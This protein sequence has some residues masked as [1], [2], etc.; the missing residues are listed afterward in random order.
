MRQ[1]GHQP[2]ATFQ[3]PL[4]DARKHHSASSQ[5]R[6]VFTSQGRGHISLQQV[7]IHV[8]AQTLATS[9]QPITIPGLK[10]TH[11]QGGDTSSS[12]TTAAHRVKKGL[13]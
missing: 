1:S 2:W 13:R 9:C 3:R 5:H 4:S 10:F 6:R 12:T 8:C 7:G 11:L